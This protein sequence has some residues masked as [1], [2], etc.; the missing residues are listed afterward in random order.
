[1]KTHHLLILALTAVSIESKAVES[2]EPTVNL[3][4]LRCTTEVRR[5]RPSPGALTSGTVR[6]TLE[7]TK[8]GAVSNYWIIEAPAP[9]QAGRDLVAATISFARSCLFESAVSDEPRRTSFVHN[10][11][12]EVTQVMAMPMP[13]TREQ[14]VCENLAEAAT[15][16]GFPMEAAKEG[17]MH[18][19]V[20]V[21]FTLS[22][23]GQVSNPRIASSSHVVFEAASLAAASNLRCKG[24]GRMVQVRVPYSFK[25]E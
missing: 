7:L 18:G 17:I 9:R 25:L 6:L 22:P 19:D 14:P 20:V 21:E 15:A 5:P 24:L 11:Q 1:M 2:W 13:R 3:Q 8:E 12:P 23:E 4:P 10:W 16:V